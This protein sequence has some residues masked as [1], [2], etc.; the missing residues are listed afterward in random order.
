VVHGETGVRRY[1]VPHR[2]EREQAV[3]A[4]QKFL[5]GKMAVARDA[6]RTAQL[7]ETLL[8]HLPFWAAWGRCLGWTFGRKRVGSGDDRRLEPR[9]VR[10]AADVTWNGA[11]CDVGE[12]GVTHIELSGRPLEPF[13]ADQLHRTG[14]VFEPVGSAQDALET[15]R[16]DFEERVRS[17]ASQ[18]EV[19]Q[20]FVRIVRPRQGVVY[21]PLWVMR[22]LYRGR[23]FQVVVDG[24]SG[25]VLYGKAPGNTLYRAAVLVG[26]MALG[27]FA[28]VTLPGAILS[29][30][31][32]HNDHPLEVAGFLFLAGMVTMYLSYRKF[33]YGEHYEYRRFRDP[34]APLDLTNITNS[35][36]QIQ[37]IWNAVEKFR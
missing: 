17:Q 27:A 4:F 15:A 12:F 36:R 32:N 5:T 35:A 14:M 18:V 9:E 2:V 25:E 29:A 16:R 21:Y 7:N 23:S 10:F 19:S 31:N 8:V 37:E 24:F 3:K 1:Q 22:Y 33:R 6:A 13:N 28:G 11:A 30:S 26:G 20:S 34:A